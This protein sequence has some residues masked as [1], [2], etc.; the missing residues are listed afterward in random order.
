MRI[1]AEDIASQSAPAP[2]WYKVK[3]EAA[4][5]EASRDKTSLN[6]VLKFKLIEEENG[7]EAQGML[8]HYISHK[9]RGMGIPLI[10]AFINGPVPPDF[11][12]DWMDFVGQEIYAK[13]VNEIFKN[14][15][16]HL[17]GERP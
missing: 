12:F 4:T 9:A 6:V 5:E 7:R 1:T 15:F 8:K 17:A 2:G 16:A 3:L 10:S 11:E 14:L 13:V